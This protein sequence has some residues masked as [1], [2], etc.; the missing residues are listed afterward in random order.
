MQNHLERR[1]GAQKTVKTEKY[2]F[3][4][5][6]W[7]CFPKHY[8]T[9]HTI[10]NFSRKLRLRL[11]FEI[12]SRRLQTTRQKLEE[13]FNLSVGCQWWPKKWYQNGTETKEKIGTVAEVK[14]EYFEKN[15]F[16]Y[17]E[18]SKLIARLV[19]SANRFPMEEQYGW[20]FSK[21]LQK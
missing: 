10:S 7:G 1:K 12:K 14:R 9:K 3:K 20:F 17:R 2:S 8:R 4:V 5:K 21:I 15:D 11:K 16:Q 19:F 13:C 6:V 18:S